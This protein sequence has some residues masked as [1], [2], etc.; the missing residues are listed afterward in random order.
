MTTQSVLRDS[1]ISLYDILLDWNQAAVFC[2]QKGG[3]LVTLNSSNEVAILAQMVRSWSSA[4]LGGN[5]SVW[6]GAK[7]PGN[8][9]TDITWVDGTSVAAIPVWAPGEPNDTDGV[10]DCIELV[11]PSDGSSGLWKDTACTGV[12]KRP[13]CETVPTA[14][15]SGVSARDA[16]TPAIQM[17]ALGGD[18][19][20]F[21]NVPLNFDD[22]V[23]FC[24]SRG[25]V[26]ASFK[27]AAEMRY[28][29]VIRAL[30]FAVYLIAGSLMPQLCFL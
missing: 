25:A 15:P 16:A 12:V 6:L 27:S 3:N 21:Y 29:G 4:A 18:Q 14:R 22:G 20:L 11:L 8:N 30:L 7:R 13:V 1:K 19:L 9:L 26:L 23:A 24:Q 28:G 17:Q 5:V 2:Q 10:E